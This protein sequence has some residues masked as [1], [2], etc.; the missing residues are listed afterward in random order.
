MHKISKN[1]CQNAS[2]QKKCTHLITNMRYTDQY[3]ECQTN[4]ER[5]QPNPKRPYILCQ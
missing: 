5:I 2:E 1:N 3:Y 4:V